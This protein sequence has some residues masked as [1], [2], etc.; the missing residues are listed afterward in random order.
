MPLTAAD[1]KFF[2]AATQ[3]D[4]ADG[5]GPRSSTV[6]QNGAENNL[7]PDV[8]AADRLTGMLRLRKV[9]PSLTNTDTAALLGGT[10]ALNEVPSDAATQMAMFAFGD[11][12]TTRA[13]AIAGLRT[14]ATGNLNTLGSSGS[15]I[16]Y[17]GTSTSGNAIVASMASAASLD[18]STWSL[19]GT[20]TT[21]SYG[22]N[23][24]GKYVLRRWVSRSGSDVTFDRTIP[25]SGTVYVIPIL[26]FPNAGTGPRIYGSGTTTASAA[27]TDAAVFLSQPFVQLAP[28][29]ENATLLSEAPGFGP[30][31]IASSNI[32]GA[33]NGYNSTL[34]YVPFVL[35]GDAATLWHEAATT[36]ATATNGGTVNVGRTN[37]DQM[38]VVGADGKEIVRFLANGPTPTPTSG[39]VSANLATGVVTFTSVTGF[40]QPVSVRHRIA[41]RTGINSVVG[42]TVNL[43]VQ[44]TQAFPSGS[45][46]STHLP[47]GDVQARATNIFA[48]Q[49]WT[50][51]F[52]DSLIGNSVTLMYAGTPA[53]TNQGAD[54]D[55]FAIVFDTGNTFTCYSERYGQIATGN[56]TVAFSPI[57]P[58]TGAPFFTLASASWAATIL[59]NSV[60]R[61]NTVAAAPPAWVTRCTVASTAGGTTKGALRLLGTL[62]A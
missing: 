61:F 20:T 21:G 30:L 8:S 25:F 55:R 9:Y 34:G 5:G 59:V 52:S 38:A 41:H 17:P 18:S 12:T 28:V 49:A 50:R 29:A 4:T 32:T 2:A 40:S 16:S 19:I 24:A 42:S 15:P 47:L 44:L 45:I 1:I 10:L 37:L 43:S 14:T 26:T 31:L 11:A 36:A 51:T 33:Y 58:A 53:V 23:A 60:L 62:D 35:A 22:P 48:Q 56:T 57:N 13:Q 3:T 27:S 39:A 7:F 46:L 54:S 6:V